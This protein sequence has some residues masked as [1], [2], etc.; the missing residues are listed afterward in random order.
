M[1]CYLSSTAMHHADNLFESVLV[2]FKQ[3]GDDNCYAPAHS[4]HTVHQNI[5]LFSSFFYEIECL[6]EEYVEKVLLVIVCRDVKVVGDVLFGVL[7]ESAA[8]Y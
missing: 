6:L 2:F 7:E 4:C 3:I 1:I 5:G 8:S